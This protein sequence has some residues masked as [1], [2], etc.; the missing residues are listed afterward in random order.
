[1]LIG[2]WD[3]LYHC[4]ITLDVFRSQKIPPKTLW[5]S[6]Y[7]EKCGYH[8]WKIFQIPEVSVSSNYWDKTSKSTGDDDS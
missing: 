7:A 1:M 6:C 5:L 8:Q 4:A 3:T 2:P